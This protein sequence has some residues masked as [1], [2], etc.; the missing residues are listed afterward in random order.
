VGS[1]SGAATGGCVGIDTDPGAY[2]GSFAAYLGTANGGGVIS[3]ILS[4]I[5]GQ[6]YAVS[7][8]LANG[9][10]NGSPVP[11]DILVQFGG[12]TLQHLTNAPAQGY[13]AY[14]FT[15]TATSSSTVLSFTHQQ[16]PSFWVLDNVSVETTTVP[17]PASLA[18]LGLGLVG[19]GFVRRKKA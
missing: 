4:T 3:Q 10:Y 17:E 2:A 7:F 14:T 18:L 12:N 13:T 15:T 11:N 6:T 16:S 5:V 1:S 8:Y 19:L 9:A